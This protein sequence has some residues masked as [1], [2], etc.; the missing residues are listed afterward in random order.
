MIPT[1]RASLPSEE[2]EDRA[3]HP[4]AG[5]LA[6]GTFLALGILFGILLIKSEVVS[7]FRIQEMF[8]FQGFHMYG[9][10]GSAVAVAAIGI[11]VVR[12]TGARALNGETIGIPEKEMGGGRRYILGGATFGLGWGLTGAC[13]AP[14]LALIGAG[15]TAFIVV[16]VSALAGTWV[17]GH[18]RPTLPH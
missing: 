10:L 7:W 9:I 5:P 14:I 17:Y 11:Q 4:S 3:S 12:R 2:T 13:P 8:R 6:L 18:L 16:L 15:A 1:T